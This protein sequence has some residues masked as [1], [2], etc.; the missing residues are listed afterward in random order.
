MLIAG[1]AVFVARPQAALA[2]HA[3]SSFE[4]DC[5]GWTI[6][7]EYIGGDEDRKGVVDVVINGEVVQETFLFDNEAGHLGH[8]DFWVLYQRTGTGSLHA[9]GTVTLYKR[10][11]GAYTTFDNSATV[12]ADLDCGE[13]PTVTPGQQGTVT[14][15]PTDTPEPTATGTP[16]P[17]ATET[18]VPTA[19]NTAEPTPTEDITTDGTVTPLATNTPAAS[20]TPTMPAEE[21]T[22]TPVPTNTPS[23][24]PPAGPTLVSTVEAAAPSGPR[25][26][27][28]PPSSRQTPPE[29]PEEGGSGFPR[30]GYGAQSPENGL[31]GAIAGLML[32]AGGLVIMGAGL[33]RRA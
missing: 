26:P 31:A 32:A 11:G 3:E 28:E 5:T 14:P 6:S 21:S 10:T 33:R 19:T 23:G 18:A 2:H 22:P 27:S 7:A 8:Q 1:V 25:Q 24:G 4:G 17:T 20:A 15:L 13:E 9:S 16:E 29:E 30:S 12:D